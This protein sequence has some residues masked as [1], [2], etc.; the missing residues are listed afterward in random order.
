MRR[1][2]LMLAAL[3]STGTVH[4]QVPSHFVGEWVV[5]WETMVKF[6]T[7][8]VGGRLDISEAGVGKFQGFG[9]SKINNCLGREAPAEVKVVSDDVIVVTVKLSEAL[10]GCADQVFRMKRAEDGSLQGFMKRG[11]QPVP[12]S[13][14]RG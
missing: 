12:I 6:G 10:E 3:V 11:D 1:W 9:R 7:A 2:I 8:Q 4:A 5:G 13:L 14:T